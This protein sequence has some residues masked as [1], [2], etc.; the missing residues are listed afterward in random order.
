M[1]YLYTR[2][3]VEIAILGGLLKLDSGVPTI[4]LHVS[5]NLLD[6]S[7]ISL[8]LSRMLTTP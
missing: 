8:A 7:M 5:I 2:L 1:L 4:N 6:K 3:K